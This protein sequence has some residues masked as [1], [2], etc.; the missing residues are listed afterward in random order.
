MGTASTQITTRK[1]AIDKIGL[2]FT[3]QYSGNENKCLTYYDLYYS[4]WAYFFTGGNSSNKKAVRY[5]NLTLCSG[6]AAVTMKITLS[7]LSNSQYWGTQNTNS[8]GT[9]KVHIM[10]GSTTL[11]TFNFPSGTTYLSQSVNVPVAGFTIA[12]EGSTHFKDKIT[13]K[14]G[15]TSASAVIQAIPKVTVTGL[16][17]GVEYQ[18]CSHTYQNSVYTQQSIANNATLT[19]GPWGY[20]TSKKYKVGRIQDTGTINVNI[21]FTS[22]V[23]ITGGTYAGAQSGSRAMSVGM[24]E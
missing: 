7:N 12:I 13:L 11:Y 15:Y 14:S 24:F 18:Y 10:N 2:P 9:F 21:N 17:S 8:N 1:N 6:N 19:M 16:I 3:L 5:D 4:P 23:T 22:S 20:G